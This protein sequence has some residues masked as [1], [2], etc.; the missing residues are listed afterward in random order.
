M[1]GCGAQLLPQP[2]THWHVDI[3]LRQGGA[4]VGVDRLQEAPPAIFRFRRMGPVQ[5]VLYGAGI[6]T[7]LCQLLQDV[8]H[9]G[10]PRIA[11]GKEAS[12]F[13]DGTYRS[14]A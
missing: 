11:E 14:C 7:G 3:P 1:E 4:D 9:M 6:G 12:I 10:V 13:A 5:V 2:A 8:R